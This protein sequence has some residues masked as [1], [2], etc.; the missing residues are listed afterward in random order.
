MRSSNK[1]LSPGQP[2]PFAVIN[3]DCCPSRRT[4]TN[5]LEICSSTSRIVAYSKSA[6][7]IDVG[8]LNSYATFVDAIMSPMSNGFYFYMPYRN[9]QENEKALIEAYDNGGVDAVLSIQA[10]FL[11]SYPKFLQEMIFY[12]HFA[13]RVVF[14]EQEIFKL[15]KKSFERS[16]EDR[17]ALAEL[18]A[19]G[20]YT[21]LEDERTAA[22]FRIPYEDRLSKGG[23]E[24]YELKLRAM[25]I[26]RMV[27]CK[28]ATDFFQEETNDE[29]NREIGKVN[30]VRDVPSQAKV[31]NRVRRMLLLHWRWKLQGK[32]LIDE[33]L[34][35][36]H[37]MNEAFWRL[38]EV[39]HSGYWS[40]GN[41]YGEE[42]LSRCLGLL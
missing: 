4:V 3:Y 18:I 10:S 8:P 28:C 20:L 21:M 2:S 30:G 27:H 32:K 31:I 15:D 35:D 7:P 1:E 13:F 6:E 24:A 19:P 23:D 29:L 42:E 39:L 25:I 33:R 40:Y 41:R 16:P 36:D 9:L 5:I 37:Y 14:W 38:E 26:H 12:S 34:H 17:E 22:Y 11:K